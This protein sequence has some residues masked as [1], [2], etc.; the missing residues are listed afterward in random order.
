MEK[1]CRDKRATGA[2]STFAVRC[3]LMKGGLRNGDTYYSRKRILCVEDDSDS[4]DVLRILLGNH[5]IS[6]AATVR[7]GLELARAGRFDLYVLNGTYPD[8]SGLELCRQIRAFDNSTPIIFFSGLSEDSIIREAINEG[9]QA[10]LIK[11]DDIE[12][13]VPKVEELLKGDPKA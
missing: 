9:A 1:Q 7:K 4:C 2:W 11:P 3:R 8:G 10:Y 5:D 13:L 6:T 12:G